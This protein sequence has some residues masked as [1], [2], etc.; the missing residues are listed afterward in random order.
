MGISWDPADVEGSVFGT[1]GIPYK[2]SEFERTREDGFTV[3]GMSPE[4]RVFIYGCELT[5][6]VKEVSV[7][8]AFSGNTCTITLCNPRGK[9]EITKQDLMKKWREDKDILATYYYKIFDRITPNAIDKFY[10]SLSNSVFG[11]KTTEKIKKGI[12][13]ATNQWNIGGSMY[14]IPSVKGATRKIF[15]TKFFS[16][17]SKKSGDVVFDFRDPVQVFFK[18]RFSPYWYFGFSGVVVGWDDSDAYLQDQVIRIRCEDITALWKRSKLT[19]QGAMYPYAR[20]EDR[21]R[22]NQ[23]KTAVS[24]YNDWS[25]SNNFSDVIKLAIFSYDYGIFTYNCHA[26][27]PGRYYSESASANT[28][29]L[30]KVTSANLSKASEYATALDNLRENGMMDSGTTTIGAT[31]GGYMFTQ[32][33]PGWGVDFSGEM[34]Y[35]GSK[36]TVVA[37]LGQSS[38]GQKK[39]G[40]INIWDIYYIHDSEYEDGAYMLNN[41]PMSPSTAVYTQLNEIE[42]PEGVPFT[43]ANLKAY[44][45]I[46][47]RYWEA[48][49]IIPKDVPNKDVTGTGWKDNKAFGICGTH[50]ALT[51]DF[52]GNFN[53]LDNIWEQCY[54]GKKELDKLIMTPND[55]IRAMT[56]G[57]PTELLC[58]ETLEQRPVAGTSFNFFRPRTFVIL[59]RRFSDRYKAAGAGKF[60]KFEIFKETNSTVYEF[61]T[62]KLKGLEYIM[63]ASPAGD[64]FIE[65]ELYDFHPLEFSQ[66]IDVKSIVKKQLPIKFRATSGYTPQKVSID[67]NAYFY[68]SSVNHPFFIMEKDRI[69]TSQTFDHKQIYTSIE[70]QGGQTDKG[71]VMDIATQDML[72]A[73]TAMTMGRQAGYGVESA[74]AKGIFVAD[75][76]GQAFKPGSELSDLQKK[77]DIAKSLFYK[78]VFFI[79]FK[80]KSSVIISKLADDYVTAM[81][82]IVD[83]ADTRNNTLFLEEARSVNTIIQNESLADGKNRNL[84]LGEL[85]LKH[86]F[87][88]LYGIKNKKVETALA[89]TELNKTNETQKGKKIISQSAYA[90][91]ANSV[92]KK[93]NFKAFVAKLDTLGAVPDANT[94]A[95][96]QLLQLAAPSLISADEDIAASALFYQATEDAFLKI[97]GGQNII[98]KTVA[99]EKR[100][101]LLGLYNPSEDMVKHYGFNP[102]EPIPNTFIKN[103]LEAYEYAR[104]VFNRLKG[105]AFTLSIDLIGRPEFCLNRPYYCERKDSIGLLSSYSINYAYGSDFLSNAKL[106]YIRRNAITYSYSLDALDAMTTGYDNASFTKQADYYYSLN[107]T[108]SGLQG[109]ATKAVTNSIAGNSP[110]GGRAIAGKLVGGITNKLIGSFLPAGG[111]FVAHDRIGHIPFDTRFGENTTPLGKTG[112]SATREGSTLQMNDTLQS[113]ADAITTLLTERDDAKIGISAQLEKIYDKIDKLKISV[114]NKGLE[115]TAKEATGE[116]ITDKKAREK[117]NKEL[118]KLRTDKSQLDREL[119]MAKTASAVLEN[120]GY[121]INE[122]LYGTG[123]TDIPSDVTSQVIEAFSTLSGYSKALLPVKAAEYIA[124]GLFFKLF[125]KHC[126]VS[127]EGYN[128]LKIVS[129]LDTAVS[130]TFE[131]GTTKKGK[132]VIKKYYV[133]SAV[134]A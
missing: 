62:K 109:Q 111:I 4:C 43:G 3:M 129:T 48:N 121:E 57:E 107:T 85:I 1:F 25:A 123:I 29:G 87:Q 23:T 30:Q 101:A 9:Y 22:S 7:Q 81:L 50:P 27:K 38:V 97:M 89:A 34:G 24:V 60:G 19:L 10:D 118:Q 36:N 16:G 70:V 13:L 46:S 56:A 96:M 58:R 74:F 6:D 37:P 116:G 17:I 72:Q 77:R 91:I 100:M 132:S 8:N 59:P 40:L 71:G 115:Y 124:N 54:I 88:E 93:T 103:G 113:L 75:G 66:K 127:G 76:F 82:S 51:Y 64:V 12:S 32:K 126:I 119:N 102:K 128:E 41:S 31:N 114:E 105:K 53:T 99:D 130:R 68:D 20:M 112:T 47:V 18:G 83:G 49:H 84:T 28:V 86:K 15:E 90:Q 35:S 131:D 63:Y 2:S 44:L 73:A 14:G 120:K 55:K 108:L 133:I 92:D 33:E 95:L 117:F 125:A 67:Q 65:P 98:I 69:R 80:E 21:V 11:A 94:K 106:E 104:I 61:L 134:S 42:F 5:R 39:V 122:K 52:I 26:S 78:N 79:L 110:G 45:D